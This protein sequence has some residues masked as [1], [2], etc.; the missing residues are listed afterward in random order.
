MLS[1][2]PRLFSA[3]VV[4]ALLSI[5]GFAQNDIQNIN[6]VNSGGAMTY[7]KVAPMNIHSHPDFLNSNSPNGIGA[8]IHENAGGVAN[9]NS[10]PNFSGSFVSGGVTYPYT[11]MGNNPNLGEK[12][13]IP[14]HIVAVSLQLENS[15][16]KTYTTI[17]VA[18]F[19]QPAL[20]SP[21]FGFTSYS[22][23]NSIQFADAVQRAEFYNMMKQNWHTNLDASLVD[24]ITIQVP[25]FVTV[26]LNGTPTQ[27][28]TYYTGKASD[29]NTF[30]L[31][32][33]K[34]FNQQIFDIVNNEINANNFD[35]NAVN[36]T[37]F[38]NTYLFALSPQGGIGDC[39]TLGYHTYFTDGGS[40]VESRWIFAYAS[41]ISPGLFNGG[42]ADVTAMSHE[43]SESFN[44]P[45][46]N[47]ATP[48]WTFP[49]QPGAC[50]GNL[51]TGDP[52]EVLNTSTVAQPIKTEGQT[53]T[54][55]P[56]TE[57]LLQWFEQGNPSN[58]LGNAFSYPDT[59]ALT[60]WATACK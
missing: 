28:R 56:Q 44:D 29:G 18:S 32:W 60:T 52:V 43:L 42:A 38:P 9:V 24:Q 47:N 3:L 59:T 16:L 41:W 25:R 45:F 36:I 17:P 27:V 33:N 4:S 14:A 48:E 31:M 20:N 7:P 39:C 35:T 53:F 23:G 12:T 51:E 2:V 10:V 1:R 49:G 6:S 21:N 50:Q 13:D 19:E 54:Y 57:A 34:F 11:M 22:S 26:K 8:A 58:A 30:V 5:A 46:L 55:H 15:D 37:L 40:P